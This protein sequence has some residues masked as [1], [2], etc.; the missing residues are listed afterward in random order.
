G[1]LRLSARRLCLGND[2]DL[3][4]GPR[5]P[6]DVAI[7]RAGPP[8]PLL[9]G[10]PMSLARSIRLG[11]LSLGALLFLAPDIFMLSTAAKSQQDIF[12]STLSLVAHNCALWDKLSIAFSRVPMGLLLFNGVVVCAL[13]LVIQV[14]DAIPCAYAMAKLKFRG[15]RAIM[16]MVMLGLLVPIHA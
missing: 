12:S 8:H 4:R 10:P 14:I 13:V 1:R 11:I 9:R 5:D 6:D 7:P 15:Q 2:G 16:M 3:S